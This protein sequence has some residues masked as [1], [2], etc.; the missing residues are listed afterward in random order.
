[1]ASMIFAVDVDYRQDKALAA[2]VTFEEW[3]NCKTTH[4][5]IL[6]IDRIA[7]YEPGQFYKRELPC[8]LALLEKLAAPPEYIIVDG[9]VY[10]GKERKK[11]LGKHLYDAL[12]GK[13]PVIGVAKTRFQDTPTETELL[14]GKSQRPLYVTAAGIDL[15]DAKVAI[16]KMCGENRIP[17]M[18]KIVDRLSRSNFSDCRSSE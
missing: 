1:M 18:L 17:A 4:Q 2:G 14:R 7:E 5:L 3:E 16:A 6:P 9:Y 10:L 11:G 12:A 13:I 15:T 8:I